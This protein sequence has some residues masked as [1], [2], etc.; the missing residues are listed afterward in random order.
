MKIIVPYGPGTVSDLTA[1]LLAERLS[2][3][4]KQGVVVDNQTG[5]GGA[6][7]TNA[8]ARSIP[9]GYTLGMLASNHAMNAAL[10]SNL[11]YD[12]VKDFKLLV[13]TTFNQFAF[14]V[15]PGL[16][17]QSLRQLIDLAKE[18][19]G[20]VTYGSS[21]NGGSPHLAMAKLAYMAG[22][23]L[24]HIPYKSNGAGVTDLLSGQ[25][26]MMSTSI[27]V[28]APHVKAG[29]LRALAVS[30]QTRSPLLPD[31][32]TVAEAG[33]AG[34]E[35]T[36]WNG[37]VGPASMSDAIASKIQNDVLSILKD[38]R[39]Q[40]R[41]AA[42]GAELAPLESVAFEKKLQAEILS[43]TEVVKSAKVKVD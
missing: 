33:I 21:G 43:W 40:E 23:Q 12:A 31:V 4:W 17:V 42:L 1:R 24:T 3:L 25:I 38:I 9:D 6:I 2:E 22:V 8:I 30:G 36:N 35:M 15:N 7:G 37:L 5:A 26:M 19:P 34:Y 13:H 28:L 16:P 20:Y 27:S 32:P 18:R 29:K 11:S 10:Y 14:C 39:T 41:V